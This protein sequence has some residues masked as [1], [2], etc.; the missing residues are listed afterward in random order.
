MKWEFQS[1]LQEQDLRS[2]ILTASVYFFG[3]IDDLHIDDQEFLLCN[4]TRPYT[5]CTG[6]TIGDTLELEIKINVPAIRGL[7]A[8]DIRAT[9]A[10]NSVTELF[11]VTAEFKQAKVYAVI[12]AVMTFTLAATASWE[13]GSYFPMIKLPLITGYLFIGIIMGPF[14]TAGVNS[15]HQ[16]PGANRLTHMPFDVCT[17]ND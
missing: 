3:Q 16:H 9:S 5:P 15:T 7:Y 1:L 13:L 12:W 2:A 4:Q 10:N 17:G 11:C 6:A 8:V 14:V